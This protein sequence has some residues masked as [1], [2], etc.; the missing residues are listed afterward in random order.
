[1]AKIGCNWSLELFDL[2][3]NQQV[4]VDYIKTGAFGAFDEYFQTMRSLKPILLHGLSHYETA[5]MKNS[6]IV[7]FDRANRLLAE[8]GSPHYGLHLAITNADM[9]PDMSIK[10][11]P[12]RMAK[13]VQIFKKKLAVPL[14]L[15][16]IPESPQEIVLYDYFP[17]SAAEQ[18]AKI[19]YDNDVGFLLDLTHA[20]IACMT[21]GWDVRD[22]L[23][24]LPLE[25]IRE[26]HVNGAGRDAGGFPD[27][28]HEAMEDEDFELLDFVLSYAAPEIISLEYIGT[29]TEAADEIR[30]KLRVQLNRLN[31]F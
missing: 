12:E 6:G 17:Y 11:I 30:E 31:E 13:V 9:A 2:I 15:E 21:R 8:C 25:R 5:G 3:T 26:I 24:A 7:D 1:M 23:R 22:Y 20:K 16:N 4:S 27:D 10:D 29:P 18:I 19:I 28:T 14:L